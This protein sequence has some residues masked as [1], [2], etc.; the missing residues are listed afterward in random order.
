MTK[1][2][3][4]ISMV[5]LSALI[6]AIVFIPIQ[7]V[8]AGVPTTLVVDNDGMAVAGNCDDSTETPYNTIQSAI[9][10]SDP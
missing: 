1:K 9:S 2:I 6:M 8:M 10:T 5:F 4:T 7:S 3:E